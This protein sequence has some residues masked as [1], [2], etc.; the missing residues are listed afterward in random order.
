MSQ[1]IPLYYSLPAIILS[2]LVATTIVLAWTEPS[3]APTGGNAPAPL[4]VSSASQYKSGALG[5][6]GLLRGYSYAIFD[7]NVGIGPARPGYKLDV[8]G[9]G[10][11][12]SG[13]TRIGNAAAEAFL[14][15]DPA[16]SQRLTL[17]LLALLRST[18]VLSM[19]KQ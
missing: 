18:I 8:Q 5:I 7:G 1:K 14:F 17:T 15:D 4:N 9:G 16:T 6:G 2:A 12:A 19:P 11:R 3:Q 10:I 13:W